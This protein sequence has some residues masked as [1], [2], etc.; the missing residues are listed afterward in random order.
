MLLLPSTGLAVPEPGL[1]RC[2]QRRSVAA[3]PSLAS[4]AGWLTISQLLSLFG[5]QSVAD[6][7]G[8]KEAAELEG[9]RSGRG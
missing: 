4:A 9:G 8:I 3:V 5:N 7:A 1:R 2:Q 6:A